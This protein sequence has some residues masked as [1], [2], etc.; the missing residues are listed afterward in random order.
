MCLTMNYHSLSTSVLSYLLQPTEEEDGM[1]VEE[2]E[3][4]DEEPS[5]PAPW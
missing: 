3:M 1:E 5:A 2:G 4:G